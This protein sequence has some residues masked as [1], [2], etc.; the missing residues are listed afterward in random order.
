MEAPRKARN[1]ALKQVLSWTGRAHRTGLAADTVRSKGT[2]L[3]GCSSHFAP[4]PFQ[5]FNYFLSLSL[6]LDHLHT[7][8]THVILGSEQQQTCSVGKKKNCPC[9]TLPRSPRSLPSQSQGALSSCREDFPF[10]GMKGILCSQLRL[11]SKTAVSG[12]TSVFLCC[13]FCR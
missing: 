8:R 11:Y 4:S 3:D 13:S 6:L 2:Y 1:G 5:L 12:F 9:C 10:T 7:L